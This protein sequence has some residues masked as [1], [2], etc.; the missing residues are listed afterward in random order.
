MLVA[1][2]KNPFQF[3]EIL[4]I[5]QPIR[6]AKGVFISG[7]LKNVAMAEAAKALRSFHTQL[8]DLQVMD[9]RAVATSA[10]RES[11]N[12][13]AFIHQVR[14]ES[15]IH[16]E[17]IGGK[18]EARLVHRAVHHF[19]DLGSKRWMLVDVGGGS[20]EIA[21][22]DQ[23]GLL[24]SDTYPIGS[25]RLLEMLENTKSDAGN[26]S[27]RIEAYMSTLQVP[28][29]LLHPAPV[30]LI[31]IGGNISTLARLS[32]IQ[33]KKGKVLMIL[34]LVNLS[35]TIER[36]MGFSFRQR[37]AT[38]GLREDRAD[39]ILPAALLYQRLATLAA[40]AEIHIPGVGLREGI[41]LDLVDV[42]FARKTD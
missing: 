21:I 33:A 2:F 11:A 17:I 19:M 6:L 14:T 13:E 4:A 30:G 1:E 22:V 38:L 10:V 15:G 28:A 23:N 12:R 7:R 25:V 3:E 34:P 32:G 24:W 5:R 29:G 20:V 37:V 39:V 16:L 18:E 35:E 8:T 41:V 26:V 27:R 31:A 36:L 42:K 9:Y 40:A